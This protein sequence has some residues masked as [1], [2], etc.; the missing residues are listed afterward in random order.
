MPNKA[1]MILVITNNKNVPNK[2]MVLVMTKAHIKITMLLIKITN[3]CI[4]RI[5]YKVMARAHIKINLMLKIVD[6]S[7][8]I[9]HMTGQRIEA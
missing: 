2:A 3:P 8:K 1:V 6:L 9:V 5:N 7:A 4:L